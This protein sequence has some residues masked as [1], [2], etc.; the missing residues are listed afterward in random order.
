MEFLLLNETIKKKKRNTHLQ[1]LHNYAQYTMFCLHFSSE[2]V[3]SLLLSTDAL[4]LCGARD[5]HGF[6]TR[7]FKVS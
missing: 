3:P 1:T 2:F 5:S 4:V 7:K 6:A